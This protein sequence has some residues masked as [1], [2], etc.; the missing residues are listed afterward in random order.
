MMEIILVIIGA[1]IVFRALYP[2]L[3]LALAKHNLFF[4]LV[5]EG[6]AKIIMYNKA[7]KRV[8]MQYT[9]FYLD[10]RWN[11]KQGLRR[12]QMTIEEARMVTEAEN[13]KRM[14]EGKKALPAWDGKERRKPERKFMG[15]GL[16]FVGLWPFDTIHSYKFR[17]QSLKEGK[18]VSREE[19]LDYV[20]AK[21]DVYYA[22]LSS[23]ETKG[24]VP[25]DIEL[26]LTI[27]IVNPYRALFRARQWLEFAVNRISPHIRQYIPAK[28]VEF[29]ELIGKD[30]LPGSE[31]FQFLEG[32]GKGL[33]AEEK[34][35]L[36]EDGYPEK[37]IEQREQT[38]WGILRILR[39]LYGIDITGIEFA[40]INTV[41][42]VYEEAAAKEWSAEMEK[43][44]IVIEASAEAEKIDIIAK[45]EAG[46]IR[47]VSEA[48]KEYG[49]I[50]LASKA[51]D[52]IKEA[53]TKPGNWVIPSNLLDFLKIGGQGKGKKGGRKK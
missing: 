6:N 3:A 18:V 43:K 12:K 24:M 27:R 1:G 26:Y 9:G 38:G 32:A 42:K 40:S 52:T 28:E 49:D 8:V 17:W 47:T 37:E 39:E 34:K 35:H 46:K 14:Q 7:F 30:Q 41:G 13:Q 20:F 22:K 25:L 10:H 11:V 15:G 51:M 19:E 23:A 36:R 44:K 21:A 29:K 33:A 45:A 53:S 5:E 48:I 16:V 2:F 31:L 4:T 50:G